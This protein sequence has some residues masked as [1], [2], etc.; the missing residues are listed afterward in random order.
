MKLSRVTF[1]DD[2]R[3]DYE[4]FLETTGKNRFWSTLVAKFRG[5]FRDGSKGAPDASFIHGITQTALQVWD[6]AAVV[7]DLSELQYEWGDEM[8]F[9]LNVGA[10]RNVKSALVVGPGCAKAI[11]TLMWGVETTRVV[12]EAENIFDNVEEAW[13]YVRKTA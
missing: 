8:D 5:R 4:F 1:T 10:D 2:N 7:L 12:T 6:P 11:A 9:L 13:K 3:I